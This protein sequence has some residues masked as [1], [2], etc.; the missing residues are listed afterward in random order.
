MATIVVRSIPSPRATSCCDGDASS[1]M[2]LSTAS[3][4]PSIPYGAN[5][6]PI[7]SVSCSCACFSSG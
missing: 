2:A 5:A 6:G 7:S 4:R 1:A 3:S